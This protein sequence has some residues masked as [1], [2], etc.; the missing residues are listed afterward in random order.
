MIKKL[1]FSSLPLFMFVNISLAQATLEAIEPDYRRSSLHTI[2]LESQ[3]FPNK[4]TVLKAYYNA[5]FPDNYNNHNIGEKTFK[6][7]DYKLTEQERIDAEVNKTGA[8]KAIASL[9]SNLTA[10]IMDSLAADYPIIIDKYLKDKQIAK[11]MV[12]KWF[13]R[14]EDGT[15]DTKLIAK[16]GQYDAS[17]LKVSEANNSARGTNMLS[18]AGMELIDKTFLTVS[19]VNFVSNEIVA[20]AIY[21]AALEAA[22]EL[23][24]GQGLANKA[25]E[26][27]YNKTKEGYSV[28]TTTYL[29]KLKWN[30]S[31]ESAFYKD[32][33]IDEEN[34]DAAK[35]TA[36]DNSELF[37]LEFIGD[38]KS[39]SLVTFSLKKRTEKQIISLSTVRNVDAV[40][41]KL[42][43]KYDVFKPMVPLLT[44]RPI[45]AK[46]GMKEGLEGGEKFEVLEV[47]Q[48]PDT[49][50][51]SYERVGTVKVDKKS[52]WDNRYNLADGEEALDEDSA[53]DRTTFKGG[54]KYLPGMLIRQIK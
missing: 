52:I 18:D 24:M 54:K 8:G 29:Y 30:D 42:Q 44:G 53:L 39:T 1:L 25:A 51:S 5:K 45:T 28:W 47:V 13:N 31:I 22:K 27:V 41:A 50:L 46:I 40:Y 48:D 32:L 12:A 37:E 49:G 36:F 3:D 9:G 35:K 23:P 7:S 2:L 21:L 4:E 26:K 43:K 38:E 10:G 33:W 6:Y 17:A 20:K 11:K 14:Q 16:R 34:F 19:R 15:F